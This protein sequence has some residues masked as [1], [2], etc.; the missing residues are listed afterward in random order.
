MCLSRIPTRIKQSHLFL[1]I[2]ERTL[3]HL[4]KLFGFNIQ[5]K[6]KC[7]LKIFLSCFHFLDLKVFTITSMA[8]HNQWQRAIKF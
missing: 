2:A 4:F 6:T 3:K 8:G 7:W 1:N 5:E